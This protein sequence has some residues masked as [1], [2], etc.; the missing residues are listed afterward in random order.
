MSWWINEYLH[1]NLLYIFVFPMSSMNYR[2]QYTQIFVEAS[3][4]TQFLCF[5]CTSSVMSSFQNFWLHIRCRVI[6]F[7]FFCRFH[8]DFKWFHTKRGWNCWHKHVFHQLQKHF[9]YS[10]LIWKKV[11]NANK[12]KIQ[13]KMNEEM[14]A[15]FS[16]HTTQYPLFI[17][18][19]LRIKKR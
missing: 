6:Y 16:S 15:V 4:Y 2:T 14:K 11:I 13:I 9:S 3:N 17:T 8:F 10:F 1:C 19:P 12:M 18:P 5:V 7:L